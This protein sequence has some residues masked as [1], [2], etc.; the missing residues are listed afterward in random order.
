MRKLIINQ[1][2]RLVPGKPPS[3]GLEYYT[4][5]TLELEYDPKDRVLKLWQRGN[6]ILLAADSL[7]EM[8]EFCQPTLEE[9]Y[10]E[11]DMEVARKMVAESVSWRVWTNPS[12][13]DLALPSWL[14]EKDGEFFYANNKIPLIREIRV[15]FGLG[16]KEAKDLVEDILKELPL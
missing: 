6:I 1:T 11:F 5:P 16:L 8:Q 10:P 15:K 7:A 3:L 2:G 9:R 4:L 14:R 12:P 13:D